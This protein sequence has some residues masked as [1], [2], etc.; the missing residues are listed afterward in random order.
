M[1]AQGIDVR[2][3]ADVLG[4]SDVS[5]ALR[6]CVHST[7]GATRRAATAMGRRWAERDDP[8]A[9]GAVIFSVSEPVNSW[10]QTANEA[11]GSR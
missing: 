4:H 5:I 6:T 3:V 9:V 2:T 8:Y 7:E 10:I 11:D 1:L